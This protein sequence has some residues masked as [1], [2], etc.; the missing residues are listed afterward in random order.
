MFSCL[1]VLIFKLRFSVSLENNERQ[2]KF[3]LCIDLSGGS[4]VKK[5][6][7]PLNMSKFSKVLLQYEKSNVNVISEGFTV[8]SIMYRARGWSHHI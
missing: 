4:E 6:T 3:A 2:V 5:M 1:I 7:F 8:Y